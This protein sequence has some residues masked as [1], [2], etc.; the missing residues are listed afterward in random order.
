[1]RIYLIISI[2][3]LSLNSYSQTKNFIDQPYLETTASID[4]LIT[5]DEIYLAIIIDEND[6]RGRTSVEVLEA[7]MN[8]KLIGLGIDTKTQLTV[9]DISS[10]FQKYF[11]RGT[12]VEKSKEYELL[13][14]DAKM[15]GKVIIELESIEISNVSINKL[16]YSKMD[17]LK[18]VL[19]QN[20]VK[21]A[22]VQAENLLKPLNQE[23]GKAIYISHD[24][25]RIS[26]LLG[27]LPGVQNNSKFSVGLSY[28]E[29]DPIDIEFDKIEIYSSATVKF[30]IE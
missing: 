1:M 26:S 29:S 5:P 2:V 20:V 18:L 28:N 16:D 7:R 27:N 8:A 17:E 13:V 12:S 25:L 3:F 30:A 23:L 15:A 11:L 4:T 21:K 19:L 24:D 6:T 9:S 14:H 10:N 22:K